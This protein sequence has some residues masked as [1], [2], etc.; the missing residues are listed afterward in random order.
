MVVKDLVHAL[1]DYKKEAQ[2]SRLLRE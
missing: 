1:L 2:K